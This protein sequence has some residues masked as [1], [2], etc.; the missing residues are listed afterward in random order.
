[1]NIKSNEQDSVFRYVGVG[2][3]V[4][5]TTILF[6]IFGYGFIE[7]KAQPRQPLLG[8]QKIEGVAA[9]SRRSSVV[10]PTHFEEIM[11][12]RYQVALDQEKNES[13]Q[14]ELST[15][16]AADIVALQRDY[17]RRFTEYAREE[18]LKRQR[19]QIEVM[20]AVQQLKTKQVKHEVALAGAVHERKIQEVVAVE[21]SKAPIHGLH[22]SPGATG[23]QRTSA[24]F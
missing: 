7:M 16:S 19:D 23:A 24:S 3:A 8:S 13:A 18:E 20:L 22:E 14:A 11:R 12:I 6:S 5:I 17:E 9:A 10:A 1:M 21:L 4:S 2:L 15:P